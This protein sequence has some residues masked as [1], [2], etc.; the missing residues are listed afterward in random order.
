MLEIAIRRCDDANVDGVRAVVADALV[1]ALLQHAQQ[2]AL[3]IERNLADLVEED[4][5]AVGEL[6]TPDPIAMRARE[7]AFH[8]AEELALEQLVRNRCAIDLHERPLRCA[9]CA[10]E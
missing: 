9:G 10:R 7:R 4:R 6:E 2:L 5:A 1:L 3:Q 8:V